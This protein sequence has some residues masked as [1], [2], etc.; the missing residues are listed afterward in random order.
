MI[1]DVTISKGI[2]GFAAEV[3]VTAHITLHAEVIFEC[4]PWVLTYHTNYFQLY[5][6]QVEAHHLYIS[7][8]VLSPGDLEIH[9]PDEWSLAL[10]KYAAS[11][12]K[13]KELLHDAN[14]ELS[15]YEAGLLPPGQRGAIC[16]GVIMTVTVH[17]RRY[18]MIIWRG[19]TWAVS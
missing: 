2:L 8:Q 12:K 4:Q 17:P 13:R 5:W 11:S 9:M 6:K 18:T 3:H 19:W 1:T 15:A 16:K 14:Y 10:R 7:Q